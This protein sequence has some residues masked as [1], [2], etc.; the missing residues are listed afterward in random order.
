MLTGSRRVRGLGLEG[1]CRSV[2]G[3]TLL[4]RPTRAQAAD[5][6]HAPTIMIV[7]E[8]AVPPAL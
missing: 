1:A 2:G 4:L 5:F 3:W 7:A 6:T 8:F